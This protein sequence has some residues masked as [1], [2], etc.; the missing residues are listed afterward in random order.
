[1]DARQR[2]DADELQ[3]ARADVGW[4]DVAGSIHDEPTVDM[5]QP[6]RAAHHRPEDLETACRILDDTV[7]R[8]RMELSQT[9]GRLVA[10]EHRAEEAEMR[11][12]QELDRAMACVHGGLRGLSDA[13]LVAEFVRRCKPLSVD[14]GGRC[15]PFALRYDGT[16]HSSSEGAS[17]R[18]HGSDAVAAI[19]RAHELAQDSGGALDGGPEATCAPG[20]SLSSPTRS[21]GAAGDRERAP[22][23]PSAQ[24][25]GADP[26]VAN[27]FHGALALALGLAEELRCTAERQV[28]CP[29][30]R[31]LE[32]GCGA[33]AIA[34]L[35]HD[36]ALEDE[37]G[38]ISLSRSH[39]MMCG[40]RDGS[41]E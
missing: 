5:R 33:V 13:D 27:G 21:A 25:D 2:S 18:N 32:I 10:A 12:S 11:L 6:D 16:W 39:L 30:L 31:V 14:F 23:S 34:S 22:A 1:M 24:H 15:A 7:T 4:G 8:L 19:V 20:D 38:G 9:Q 36:L 40:P 29:I 35:G 3:L 41:A 17:S 37:R 26:G 28:H